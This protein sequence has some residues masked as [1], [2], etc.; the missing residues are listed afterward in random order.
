MVLNP[1]TPVIPASTPLKAIKPKQLLPTR[2]EGVRQSGKRKTRILA[3][4]VFYFVVVF[5][6]VM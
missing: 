5:T 2:W 6:T 1:T 4:V 3:K